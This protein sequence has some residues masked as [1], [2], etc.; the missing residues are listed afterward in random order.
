M[1][2]TL[3]KP[4]AFVCDWLGSTSNYGRSEYRMEISSN[5][6]YS[7]VHLRASNNRTTHY[8]TT[9]LRI[10]LSLF[11][12]G[13]LYVQLV[14]QPN[15]L[16]FPPPPPPWK[17]LSNLGGKCRENSSR[18]SSPK[19][20]CERSKISKVLGKRHVNLRSNR[21]FLDCLCFVLFF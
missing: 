12:S 6:V 18:P 2:S 17:T 16:A 21:C 11:Y 4:L 1:S 13:I 8:T 3:E 19:E 5:Y 7:Q 10:A 20:F 9:Q 15:Q 14:F